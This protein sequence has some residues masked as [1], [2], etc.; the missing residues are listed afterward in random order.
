MRINSGKGATYST[1]DLVDGC[2]WAQY[3]CG[4][5]SEI[6]SFHGNGAHA[7]FADGHTVFL[8]E[9]TP[10]NILRALITR[11]DAKSES[12]PANFE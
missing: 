9:S 10:K 7:V 8:K 6:F 2:T 4:P 5:N 3:D 11:N 1:P 12:A